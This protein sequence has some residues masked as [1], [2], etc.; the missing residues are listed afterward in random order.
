MDLNSCQLVLFNV[1]LNCCQL[2]L[3]NVGLNCCQLVL[4]NVGLRCFIFIHC[5]VWVP[6]GLGRHVLLIVYGSECYLFGF[7]LTAFIIFDLQMM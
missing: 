2:V 5:W 1:D 3:F 4:F 7:Y 6:K